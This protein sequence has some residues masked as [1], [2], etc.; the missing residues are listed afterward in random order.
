MSEI[1]KALIVVFILSVATFWLT[2]KN[3]PKFISVKEFNS[4]RNIWLAIVVAAFI[5]HNIWLFSLIILIGSIFAI[6]GDLPNRTSFYLLVFCAVPQLQATI[7]GVLGIRYIFDLTYPRLLVITIFLALFINQYLV[8]FFTNKRSEHSQH[9]SLAS[10]KFVI[11]YI[12]LIAYLN[13]RQNTTTNALREFL[14]L[15]LD[16]YIPYFMISRSAVTTEQ[17]NRILLALLIGIMPL[18]VIGIFETAKHWNLYQTLTSSL[19][20]VAHIQFYDMRAG[21]LRASGPFSSPIVYGYVLVVAFGLLLYLKPLLRDKKLTNLASAI[22]VLCLLSTMARGP[23]VGL[24]ALI[25]VYIATGKSKFKHFTLLAF[26]SIAGFTILSF[27]TFGNK[28]IDLLPFIGTTRSDTIDYRERLIDNAWIVFQDNPWLGSTFFLETDEMESM[29]QGQGIIDLVNTYIQIV[30]PY[31]AVGLFLFLAIFLGLLFSC[32]RMINKLPASEV[33]LIRMGRSL[34][35]IMSSV[36]LIIFTA[37]SI[38][39]IPTVYWALAGLMASYIH[40]SKTALYTHAKK[41]KEKMHAL[42]NN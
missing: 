10:D 42:M 12:G 37:S 19:T 25:L 35:A 36:L 33:D 40:M 31:G 18:A 34:V 38:D 14:M 6:S 28:I 17:M 20:R 29:R 26:S 16:I 13:F 4:W 24:I 9:F 39:Y 32:Y 30:L 3:L 21:S 7:P 5:S 1:Y 8:P 27:T 15:L 23:W 11:L 41:N 2:K 22:I